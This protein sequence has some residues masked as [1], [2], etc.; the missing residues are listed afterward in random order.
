[1][2]VPPAR[3]CPE[4][5]GA[6]NCDTESVANLLHARKNAGIQCRPD[7][8][9]GADQILVLVETPWV[10]VRQLAC[11]ELAQLRGRDCGRKRTRRPSMI[12]PYK[13][14]ISPSVSAQAKVVSAIRCTSFNSG[15]FQ[16]S[17]HAQLLGTALRGLTECQAEISFG[18]TPKQRV[19]M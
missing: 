5:Y 6:C 13:V 10:A 8:A 11:A 16:R 7:P 12:G 14:R 17:A 3:Q 9:R 15:R 1:M 2:G 19:A 18:T 4:E